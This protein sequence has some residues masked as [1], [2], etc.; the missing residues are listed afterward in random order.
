[1][2]F[3]PILRQANHEH[4]HQATQQLAF[5]L[6]SPRQGCRRALAEHEARTFAIVEQE[7]TG[8]QFDEPQRSRLRVEV[9]MVETPDGWVVSDV[10][11]T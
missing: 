2:L 7:V 10:E 5:C 4:H 3:R 8:T 11:T 6:E 9:V 1:M